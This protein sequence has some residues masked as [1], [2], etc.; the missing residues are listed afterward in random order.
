MLQ[1]ATPRKLFAVY[2]VLEQILR[3]MQP[4]I[5]PS[6]PQADGGRSPISIYCGRRPTGVQSENCFSNDRFEFFAAFSRPE[7]NTMAT[8]R[9]QSPQHAEE[10]PSGVRSRRRMCLPCRSD[11]PS[12]TDRADCRR[13]RDQRRFFLWVKRTWRRKKVLLPRLVRKAAELG[14]MSGGHLSSTAGPV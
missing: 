12:E 10:L 1:F 7:R 8:T 5:Q 3:R 14:L 2:C 6:L 11:R 13:M 4:G 9:H